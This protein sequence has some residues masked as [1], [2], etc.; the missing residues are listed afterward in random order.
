MRLAA[1]NKAIELD[2]SFRDAWFERAS[3]QQWGFRNAE[4]AMTDYQQANALTYAASGLEDAHALRQMGDL[5]RDRTD[6]KVDIEQAMDYYRR[7]A[8]VNPED[9]HS[10]IA[11]VIVLNREG[12]REQA[13]DMLAIGARG[14]RSVGRYYVQAR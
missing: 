1:L 4:Q 3:L 7:A 2:P 12:E 5:A 13:L 9:P 8:A 6:G 14:N 11:Q 10:Q